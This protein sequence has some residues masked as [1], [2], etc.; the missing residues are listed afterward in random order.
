M[1]NTE[2]CS[3]GTPYK[4]VFSKNRALGARARPCLSRPENRLRLRRESVPVRAAPSPGSPSED[5]S[6]G[7]RDDSIE[8]KIR[9]FWRK[10]PS[11]SRP[12]RLRPDREPLRPAQ[13]EGA[14]LG[15]CG[16]GWGSREQQRLGSEGPARAAAHAALPLWTECLPRGGPAS[17]ARTRGCLCRATPR[18]QGGPR[19]PVRNDGGP[20][21]SGKAG[22][23]QARRKKSFR[24]GPS[25]KALY[26]DY[27]DRDAVGRRAMPSVPPP[28]G[29]RV[30]SWCRAEPWDCERASRLRA[31]MESGV[32]VR[33]SARV[34][35]L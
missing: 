13:P 1:Q 24:P 8:L 11:S 26:G 4:I 2:D 17:P 28:W 9:K 30:S 29:P 31:P 23:T 16:A 3:L 34:C 21:S 12:G 10:R 22:G 6:S 20:W 19:S 25:T 14:E 35:R 15:G 33:A 5:S 7:N 27:Q 18:L 32:S